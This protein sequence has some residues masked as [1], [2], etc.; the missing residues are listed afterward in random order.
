MV[1]KFWIE[2]RKITDKKNKKG[3]IAKVL[4][5][6]SSDYDCC[7]SMAVHFQTQHRLKIL[8]ASK[9]HDYRSN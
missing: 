5:T 2:E 4:L 8:I 9:L 7:L 6:D 1:S 3:A